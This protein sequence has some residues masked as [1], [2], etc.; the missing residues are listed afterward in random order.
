MCLSSLFGGAKA[1]K[2]ATVDPAAERR[3]A[4]AEAAAKANEQ[5]LSDARRKRQQKG[6]LATEST[7]DSVLASAGNAAQASTVLGS[8]SGG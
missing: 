5:L 8:G 3:A 2:T 7:S 4:E 6:I 1:P